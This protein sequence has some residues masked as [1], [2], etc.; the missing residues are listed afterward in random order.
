MRSAPIQL[1]DISSLLKNV[2]KMSPLQW[3]GNDLKDAAAS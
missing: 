1:L 2:F 3:M